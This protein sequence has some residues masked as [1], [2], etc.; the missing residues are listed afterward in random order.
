MLRIKRAYFN[1]DWHEKE[2]ICAQRLADLSR[3][4]PIL[5]GAGWLSVR[6]PRTAFFGSTG[7]AGTGR[8]HLSGPKTVTDGAF[9]PDPQIHAPG[10]GSGKERIYPPPPKKGLSQELLSPVA[11][12]RFAC[13]RFLWR[14]PPPPPRRVAQAQ[15][16]TLGPTGQAQGLGLRL[17]WE[18]VGLGPRGGLGVPTDLM[19]STAVCDSGN[20]VIFIWTAVLVG[21]QVWGV[22]K[23]KIVERQGSSD[24]GVWTVGSDPDSPLTKARE[25]RYLIPYLDF[26]SWTIILFTRRLH[27]LCSTYSGF[28]C[29]IC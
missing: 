9:L 5:K 11:A 3:L 23:M 25:L 13:L 6:F 22:V 1:I 24:L 15:G 14:Q 2:S 28:C 29:I 17:W 26:S 18:K 10:T 20:G 19:K 4:R 8:F 12:G 7:Q 16:G 27:E 21:E